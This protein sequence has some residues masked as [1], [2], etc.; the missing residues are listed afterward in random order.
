MLQ[1]MTGYDSS[2]DN[3]PQAV[4]MLVLATFSTSYNL[5]VYLRY[6]ITYRRTFIRM[7][8]CQAGHDL[9]EPATATI[10]P[11][12]VAGSSKVWSVRSGGGKAADDE[13][14]VR[15]Q[16]VTSA[17]EPQDDIELKP[18]TSQGRTRP[19]AVA[20]SPHPNTEQM[21]ARDTRVVVHRF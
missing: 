10:R 14:R 3:S 11:T 6:N 12:T 16:A 7:F 9:G 13:Q 19:V 8:R 4:L 1:L 20:W 2:D 21:D 18:S 5:P 15:R 17:C